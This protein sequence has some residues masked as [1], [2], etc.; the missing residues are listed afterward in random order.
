MAARELEKELAAKQSK[1][2]TQ[3]LTKKT[4]GNASTTFGSRTNDPRE[5]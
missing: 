4:T 5:C 1:T 3:Q 2:D